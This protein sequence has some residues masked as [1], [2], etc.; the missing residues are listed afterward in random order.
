MPGDCFPHLSLLNS[1]ADQRHRTGGTS[2]KALA[3][4][5]SS[6]ALQEAHHAHDTATSLVWIDKSK[7]QPGIDALSSW[8]YLQQSGL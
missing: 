6:V 8:L 7:L 5:R 2:V 3:A 1:S 4:C